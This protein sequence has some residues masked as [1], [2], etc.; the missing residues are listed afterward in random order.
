MN[1]PFMIERSL[2]D[3]NDIVTQTK[4]FGY[5]VIK[6]D[7]QSFYEQM[8]APFKGSLALSFE[9]SSKTEIYAFQEGHKITYTGDVQDSESVVKFIENHIVPLC[10]IM[11][12]DL[13]GHLLLKNKT[14]VLL[15]VSFFEPTKELRG[16]FEA[17]AVK[18]QTVSDPAQIFAIM[19]NRIFDSLL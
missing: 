19:N 8:L 1:Q 6:G 16:R 9:K 18:A 10:P 17:A 4:T 3:L 12:P 11:T 14:L 5:V 13:F 15:S 7:D 2:E